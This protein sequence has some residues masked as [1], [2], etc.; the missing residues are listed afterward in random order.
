V[1]LGLF[2]DVVSVQLTPELRMGSIRAKPSS[3]EVSLHVASPTMRATL[4]EIGFQLGPVGLDEHGRITTVRLIPTLAPFKASPTQSAF[5]IGGISVVPVN[6]VKQ[7]QLT[8]APH[9]SMT[10][11]MLASL[12]LAGVELSNTFQIAQLVL[13]NRTNTV[14]V[15]LKSQAAGQEETGTKC[16]TLSVRLDN[17]AQIAELLLN[18][19]R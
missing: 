2:L 10:M 19:I 9:S 1:I 8:P 18:P 6:S 3:R 12:E 15:T 16:E 17:S 5:Q 14:R 11:H 4:S 13:K 7:M